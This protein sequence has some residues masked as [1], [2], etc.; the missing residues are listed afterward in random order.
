MHTTGVGKYFFLPTVERKLIHFWALLC[1]MNPSDG[2]LLVI[3]L[4]LVDFE[5]IG[6]S[7]GNLS[8]RLK[9]MKCYT[10]KDKNDLPTTTYK[11]YSIKNHHG[12]ISQEI[13]HKR[14][15]KMIVC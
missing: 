1:R 13:T 11:V 14:R 8:I 15:V 9:S 2:F 12:P 3:A 7:A 5:N 6:Q 4:L 10:G